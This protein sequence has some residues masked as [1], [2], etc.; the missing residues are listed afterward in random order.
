MGQR[1]QWR[2]RFFSNFSTILHLHIKY[3][4]KSLVLAQILYG[5]GSDQALGVVIFGLNGFAG[6]FAE[7]D[8]F[9][10]IEGS[11]FPMYVFDLPEV[12][13]VYGLSVSS[14]IRV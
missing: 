6:V 11:V 9:F 1:S 8:D 5:V 13:A 10:V 3:G 4:P 14:P 7:P 2:F 12:M